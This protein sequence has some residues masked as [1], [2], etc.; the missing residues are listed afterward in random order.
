MMPEMSGYEVL[1]KLREDSTTASIPVVVHTSKTLSDEE[2]EMLSRDV[3]AILPKES[4][5]RDA[6]MAAVRNALTKAGLA[7]N[8]GGGP[9]V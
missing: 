2:R 4:A 1:A 5:S 7:L 3:V 9:R 8:T 6:A